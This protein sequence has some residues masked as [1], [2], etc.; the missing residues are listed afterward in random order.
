MLKKLYK[1]NQ[2]LKPLKRSGT[3]SL[4]LMTT[5]ILSFVCFP[6]PPV[7]IAEKDKIISTIQELEFNYLIVSG[8]LSEGMPDL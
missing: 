8:G 2:F 6:S 7:T 3:R 5:R 4:Q 1:K